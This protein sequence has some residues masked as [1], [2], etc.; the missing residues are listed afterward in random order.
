MNELA[1]GVLT[2][3][4]ALATGGC[5]DGTVPDPSTRKCEVSLGNGTDVIDG[6]VEVSLGAWTAMCLAG[7][8]DHPPLQATWTTTAPFVSA[9]RLLS[10]RFGRATRRGKL[11][12]GAAPGARSRA[13]A[14]RSDDGV[15]LLALIERKDAEQQQQQQLERN[16]AD[17]KELRAKIKELEA[18]LNASVKETLLF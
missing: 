12:E 6:K 4:P 10:P 15:D 18:A 7:W 13:P 3:P 16:D 9:T 1:G 5:G 11:R 17:I 8:A 2:L 14:R